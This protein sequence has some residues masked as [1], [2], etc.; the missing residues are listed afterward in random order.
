MGSEKKLRGW[1]RTM[2]AS[3]API[4]ASAPTGARVSGG[5]P[6]WCR[7]QRHVSRM[8]A[9]KT[10]RSVDGTMKNTSHGCPYEY[11]ESMLWSVRRVCTL[12]RHMRQP[13]LLVRHCF[14]ARGSVYVLCASPDLQNGAAWAG[15][16]RRPETG[17]RARSGRLFVLNVRCALSPAPSVHPGHGPGVAQSG[18]SSRLAGVTKARHKAT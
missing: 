3:G 13:V 15:Q 18:P 14:R 9:T 6:R 2:G 11:S 17:G 5:L 16:R 8:C 1:R 4:P 7:R 12:M 10:Y